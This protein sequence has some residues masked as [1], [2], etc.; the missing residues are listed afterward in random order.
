MIAVPCFGTRIGWPTTFGRRVAFGQ[1][2]H[3][4]QRIWGNHLKLLDAHFEQAV[5]LSKNLAPR[6]LVGLF[7]IDS[8]RAKV[9]CGAS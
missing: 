1:P 3:F 5:K 9:S 8:G 6:H 4:G 7:P 2:L